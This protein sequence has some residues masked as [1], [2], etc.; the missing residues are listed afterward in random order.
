MHQPTSLSVVSDSTNASGEACTV[1]CLANPG[2]GNCNA[3]T[4]TCN[5]NS[6]LRT[7]EYS[8]LD[9]FGK[10]FSSVGITQ[11]DV[12]ET[13][14]APSG[15]CKNVNFA[16][17]PSSTSTFPDYLWMCHTCCLPGGPGCSTSRNQTIT[18]N[19]FV[20]RQESATY[21]CSGVTLTP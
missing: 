3:N 19:G 21:S 15:T 10:S 5:Y 18:V 14:T 1:S 17:A 16:S 4:N 20:V 13:W 11:A 9:Q 7:R 6:Y 12:E 2:S 8:V